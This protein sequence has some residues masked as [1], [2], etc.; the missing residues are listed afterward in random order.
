MPTRLID[1][2]RLARTLTEREGWTAERIERAWAAPADDSAH[3]ALIAAARPYAA[4][5]A[6]E[7]LAAAVARRPR[8]R[9]ASAPAR[10]LLAAALDEGRAEVVADLLVGPGAPYAYGLTNER[11]LRSELRAAM[12]GGDPKGWLYQ[13]DAATDRPADLGYFVGARVCR[14]YH[15]RAPDEAHALRTIRRPDDP[16]ALPAA[17]GYA[18]YARPAAVRA[19]G[20]GA[21]PARGGSRG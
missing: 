17:G 6:A 8:S 10:T 13:G 16:E 4:R 9:A 21:P 18:P 3:R 19:A 2:E 12:R 14:A 7:Q 5:S 11:R 15:D 20:P 1:A